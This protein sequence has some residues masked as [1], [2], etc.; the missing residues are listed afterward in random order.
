MKRSAFSSQ[1]PAGPHDP[2]TG[3]ILPQGS[4]KFDNFRKG[5][6]QSGLGRGLAALAIPL[7]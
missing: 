4:D 1:N 3:I 7:Q 5:Q 6:V 2:A